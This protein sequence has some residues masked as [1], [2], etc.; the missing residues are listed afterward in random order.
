MTIYAD[1]SFLVSFLYPGDLNHGKARRFFRPR[2]QETWLTTAWSQFETINSLRSLCLL[3]RGPSQNTIE[4][5]RR[6]FKHWHRVGPFEFERTD[7][8]EA[9]KDAHQ[10]SAAL[11]SRM[12]ARAADALHVALLEQVNPDLFVTFDKEQALLATARGYHSLRIR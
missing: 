10:I 3:P 4:S 2:S 9:I 1:T 7:W 12:K 8:E 6:L 11:A 5:I